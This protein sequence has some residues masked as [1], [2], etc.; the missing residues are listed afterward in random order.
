MLLKGTYHQ[1]QI[2]F[3]QCK[4]VSKQKSI[5]DDLKGQ[6]N[7]INFKKQHIINLIIR[8]YIKYVYMLNFK[9]I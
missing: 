7:A 4:C 5:V 3:L 9:K 6:K 8:Y 2:I 1:N